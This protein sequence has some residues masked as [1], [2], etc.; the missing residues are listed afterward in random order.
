[1]VVSGLNN[2]VLLPCCLPFPKNFCFWCF[3]G[4]QPKLLFSTLQSLKQILQL[5]HKINL[6]YKMWVIFI[7]YKKWRHNGNLVL[8]PAI[9]N[10]HT[11]KVHIKLQYRRSTGNCQENFTLVCAT[12]L[13]LLLCK[14]IKLNFIT[15]AFWK[16]YQEKLLCLKC[17]GLQLHWHRIWRLLISKSNTWIIYAITVVHI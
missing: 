14:L 6:H 9:I 4:F 7:W 17:F 5:N 3:F 13:Q 1:M 16:P 15:T 8:Q 2:Q 11:W 12:L 10:M